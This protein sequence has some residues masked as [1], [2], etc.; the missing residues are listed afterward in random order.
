M[1]MKLIGLAAAAFL[2]GITGAE[3]A[4]GVPVYDWTGFY[5]GVNGGYTWTHE[6]IKVGGD[7]GATLPAIA[8]G[9]L[10]S[11]LAANPDGPVGGVQAGYNWRFFNS[12][13]LGAEADA[14]V[15]QLGQSQ[16]VSTAVPGFL[17]FTTFGQQKMDGIGTLRVRAG[18]LVLPNLLAYA[19][20]GGA[21][22]HVS[23]RA[24]VTNAGCVGICTFGTSTRWRFGPTFGG[25]A[26]YAL[27]QHWS[28]KGEYL[29]YNLGSVSETLTDQAGR[30]AGTAQTFNTK[31]RG[32]L[33]RVGLNFKFG[34]PP[35]PIA[36]APAPPAPEPPPRP[37][38]FIV[39][40]DFDKA[41]LTP[42]ARKVLDQAAQYAKANGKATIDVTGYTDLS[43]TVA[44]NQRLSER[45]A[46]AVAQYLEHLGIP[47]QAI[48]EAGRGKTNPRVPTADGVREPQNRRVEIQMP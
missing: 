5:L 6:A 29:Y 32:N 13:V 48:V 27:D 43:G 23:E 14:D 42:E 20:A 44:Y 21:V 15:A 24:Q 36:E 2:A 38:N 11:S 40:F 39:F 41:D 9:V 8:A 4:D 34:A 37:Q 3:A 46:R 10:P 30:F 31:F 26:E 35:A 22:G 17:P 16:T 18:Y 19:T 1:R 7:P 25:G 28:I 45:R 12:F 47:H 33:V